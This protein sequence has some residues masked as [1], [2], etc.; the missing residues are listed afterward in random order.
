[1]APA[2]T[3]PPGVP[4]GVTLT[5]MSQPEPL[6]S[7]VHVP[8]RALAAGFSNN[9]IGTHTGKT[10]MLPEL[11]LLLG[12]V[13]GPAEFGEYQR[14]TVEEN[15]LAKSTAANRGNTLMY[16]KQLYGLRPD[17]PVFVAMRELWDVNFNDQ[18]ILALLCASARDVLLR[19]TADAVVG[20]A[21]GSP[22]AAADLSAGIA[23]AFPGRYK[24][25]TL[26]NLGQNIASSWTQSGL[27]GGAQDKR[28]ATPSVDV[29]ALVYALYL[30]H[31]EGLA[32]PTLFAS[33]WTRMLD[34]NEAD[35]RPMAE[36][37]GRSG[38]LEY[39]SSGGMTEI[40]FRHL[41]DLTN[42]TAS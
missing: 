21:L 27:L 41:D 2:V 24:P 42:W 26:R 4:P 17:I 6:M 36:A 7:S 19:S 38:W 37:A 25:S 20:T 3:T 40:G 15:A 32:G 5:S 31:L 14:A 16:L 18:P 10:M 22:V 35:L 33:R 23:Q 30:G 28:R 1:M 9:P 13:P 39:R 11:R 29:P 12:A 34:R 8:D